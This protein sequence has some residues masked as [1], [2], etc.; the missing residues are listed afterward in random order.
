MKFV[1]TDFLKEEKLSLSHS[2]SQSSLKEDRWKE[3][4][5]LWKDN[6][7]SIFTNLIICATEYSLQDSLHNNEF[8]WSC[9]LG[10]KETFLTIFKKNALGKAREQNPLK[11]N[12]STI[13]YVT[14]F[15][16]VQIFRSLYSA[17]YRNWN[18]STE[19]GFQQ[20]CK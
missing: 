19:F 10:T 9:I 20:E 18:K 17:I 4:L 2:Y 3:M 6:L 12:F 16:A 7:K 14:G 8:R 1:N 15:L 5:F 13:L 11:Y